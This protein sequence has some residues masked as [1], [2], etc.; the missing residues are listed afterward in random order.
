MRVK[1]GVHGRVT[2]TRSMMMPFFPMLCN[3]GL[4]LPY[5]VLKGRTMQSCRM[6]HAARFIEF[7]SLPLRT[8]HETSP[9]TL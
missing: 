1:R 9:S 3:S 5:P 6:F 8:F 4:G 7:V 2:N